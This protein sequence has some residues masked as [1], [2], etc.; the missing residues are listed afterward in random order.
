MTTELFSFVLVRRA[1]VPTETLARTFGR[2]GAAT[3]SLAAECR[4]VVEAARSPEFLP[5]LT[6][7]SRTFLENLSTFESDVVH[8][9]KRARH[10]AYT[11]HRYLTRACKKA[12]PF[13]RFTGVELGELD[14]EPLVTSW[15]EAP[16]SSWVELGQTLVRRLRTRLQGRALEDSAIPVRWNATLSKR[17]ERTVFLAMGTGAWAMRAVA[18]PLASMLE[19]DRSAGDWLR[20]AGPSASSS[21][22]ALLEAGIL[23]WDDRAELRS[24]TLALAAHDPGSEQLRRCGERYGRA[25]SL[26]ERLDAVAE[27]EAQLRA[28]L[29][30][31][32]WL[33]T[34]VFAEDRYGGLR[35]RFDRQAVAAAA[36]DVASV[37][38]FIATPHR[39][40]E[41]ATQW[42]DS[43]ID[44]E[45][46]PFLDVVEAALRVP[47]EVMRAPAEHGPA[48]TT[49]G[50][51]QKG[52]GVLRLALPERAPAEHAPI[53]VGMWLAVGQTA[54]A[55]EL[56]LS[57]AGPGFGRGFGRFLRGVPGEAL[58]AL[59]EQNEQY[60]R[61][62]G[63]FELL[64]DHAADSHPY[65]GLPS[66]ALP[67]AT[68]D[69]A[70]PEDSRI[71]LEDL[72][73]VREPSGFVLRH[74]TRGRLRLANLRLTSDD[75]GRI[76][77][78]LRQLTRGPVY[79]VNGWLDS[80][81]SA[82]EEETE[83][84]AV[85]CPRIVGPS[86]V[87]L[88]RRR[89]RVAVPQS[90]KTEAAR[91]DAYLSLAK[92]LDLPDEQF[93]NLPAGAGQS[94]AAHKPRYI[95]LGS[96]IA[97]DDLMRT[98]AR[99]GGELVVEEAFPRSGIVVEG[100]SFSAEVYVEHWRGRA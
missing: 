30:P 32:A 23:E 27:A 68:D 54:G 72:I 34:D 56:A 12:S 25:S 20:D 1:L 5:L 75:R 62:F 11:A 70:T 40:S 58:T 78:L 71:R 87:V 90:F 74:R 46:L 61:A 18:A 9:N 60:A 79:D 67:G 31:D 44:A 52:D 45:A 53:S 19:T 100:G 28:V 65:L 99:E 73:V 41:A 17:P 2:G 51:V 91:R 57:A 80:V 83:G 96:R 29:P 7:S 21:R 13:G 63:L 69:P 43:V 97:V 10:M 39:L 22:S 49:E 16:P 38:R 85:S 50:V 76:D 59:R 24:P 48:T 35:H 26:E 4:A 64:S 55:L 42:L 6:G 86:G 94:R 66:I 98:W 15:R 82:N 36:E 8:W 77:W 89:W 3:E 47:D 92:T 88:A 14:D 33:T 84:G 95:H 37:A 93:V 81:R